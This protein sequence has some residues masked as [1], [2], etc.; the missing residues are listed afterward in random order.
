[1]KATFLKAYKPSH[2][3]EWDGFLFAMHLLYAKIG[4]NT[5]Y[6]IAFAKL[7]SQC[8]NKLSLTVCEI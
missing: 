7:F 4:G 6:R 5:F 3:S 8:F 2:F 1:M